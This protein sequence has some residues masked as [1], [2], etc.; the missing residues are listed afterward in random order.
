MRR[1]SNRLVEYMPRHDSLLLGVVIY[2]HYLSGPFES[3][4]RQSCLMIPPE[5]LVCMMI[6][7]CSQAHVHSLHFVLP[8]NVPRVLG[9]WSTV[10]PAEGYFQ[11]RSS[12]PSIVSP[13]FPYPR[14]NNHLPSIAP[15]FISTR[16][17]ITTK[18][19]PFNPLCLASNKRGPFPMRS[20]HMNSHRNNQSR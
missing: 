20:P 14:F 12:G 16:N 8:I 13:T 7:L 3:T 1:A 17:L 10:L 9:S 6:L 2:F 5:T 15:L 19:H 11:R 4:T 18:H